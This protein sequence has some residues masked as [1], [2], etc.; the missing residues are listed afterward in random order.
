MFKASSPETLEQPAKTKEARPQSCG[1]YDGLYNPD[2]G[3]QLYKGGSSIQVG[4]IQSPLLTK[5]YYHKKS[6][7]IT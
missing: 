1:L 2:F 7:I 6:F 5:Y 4:G 3:Q